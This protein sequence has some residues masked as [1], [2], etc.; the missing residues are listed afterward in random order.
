M[1]HTLRMDF[2]A[3]R[4]RFLKEMGPGVAVFPAAEVVIR[5]GDVEHDFRQDSDMHYLCGFDEPHSVLLLSNQHPEHRSVLFVQ[6]RDPAREIWDGPRAGVDGAVKDFGVDAAYTIEELDEKLPEYLKNVDRL[7]YRWGCGAEFDADIQQAIETLRPLRRKGIEGPNSLHDPTKILH[8]HR[9]FKDADEVEAMRKAASIS[10]EAHKAAM[11]TAQPGAFE[12]EVEATLLSHF[13]RGGS[14]RAAYGSI[15]GSGAH[16]TI[17]HYV[18]NDGAIADGDLL[19]IDAGCE[20]QHY[21][22]DITR[23]FPAN[24]KFSAEQRAI[25]E[26][27]LRSERAGIQATTPGATLDGIHDVCVRELISGLLEIGLLEG[28]VES[29][30][31]SADYKKFYMHRTSHW[32]GMDVHD[33]GSYFSEGKARPLEPGMVF[34]IEPGIYIGETSD[35]EDRWKGIGIRIE[36]DV[37]VTSDGHDVLTDGVPTDPDA[38]EAWI[39]GANA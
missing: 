6:A 24:G 10:A 39:A 9:L 26:I 5:N 1:T 29:Q 21:A 37:L 31:E 11:R 27:V 13:R 35:V 2:S 28:T 7:Y 33:V 32:L 18:K 3:R 16:A 22:S 4:E 15:V 38:I 17:L 12:Y 8:E 14:P 20:L 25:Y 19:L 36:D 34:T 30:I 23:T